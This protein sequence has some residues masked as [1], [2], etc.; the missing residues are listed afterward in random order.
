MSISL[1][2]DEIR[3]LARQINE[4]IEGLT[5]IDSILED[6]RDDLR[7]AQELKDKADKAE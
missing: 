5:N 6:T 1:T 2:P 3:D 4:T 7:R